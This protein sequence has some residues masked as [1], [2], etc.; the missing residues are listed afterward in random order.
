M[1]PCARGSS[2]EPGT[3]I[4][5]RP[6]SAAI[7]AVI[8]DPERGAAS[9]T[10]VP[11]AS[12][13]MIRLREG[14]KARE[15]ARSPRLPG[16]QQALVRDA[17]LQFGILGGKA[18]SIPLAI[19]AIVPA[20]D[21]SDMRRGVDPAREPRDHHRARLAQPQREAG[22]RNRHAAAEALRATDHRDRGPF[23]EFDP[24]A[25]DQ[26]GRRGFELGEQRRI[27]GVAQET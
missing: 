22:A 24:P 27:G 14:K 25:N 1:Q 18:R 17:L 2:G 20:A 5:S 8:S 19:T 11:S 12:P 6:A 10:T 15:R 26:R 4:T 23:G 3:A 21:R 7:R 16:D 9:T 13:A